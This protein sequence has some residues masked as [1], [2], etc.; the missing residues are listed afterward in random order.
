M[1]HSSV[2]SESQ[3]FAAAGTQFK[4]TPRCGATDSETTISESMA[5]SKDAI[6]A[7]ANEAMSAAGSDLQSLRA[8]LNGLRDTVMKFMSQAGHEAAKSAREVTA[9]V[10]GQVGGAV[11]DLSGKGAEMASAASDQAKTFAS[12]VENI[13]R[14]N[15]LG[16]IA[17]AVALGVL[18]GLMGR[19][20]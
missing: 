13:A 9:N 3:P 10:A 19:R 14:R 17:G 5:R 12:E 16:A 4:E 15:P 8:D 7:A 20:N 1:E 2:R 6:G 11:S 18:I